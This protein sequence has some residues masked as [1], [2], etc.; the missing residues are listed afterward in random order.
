M[1]DF[2]VNFKNKYEDILCPLCKNHID[3][4]ENMFLCSELGNISTYKFNDIFSSNMDLVAKTTKEFQKLWKI[5]QSK[6]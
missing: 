1:L 4:E 6:L 2:K 3:N 5:R